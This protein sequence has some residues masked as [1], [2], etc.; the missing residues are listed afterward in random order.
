MP[1]FRSSF[2]YRLFRVFNNKTKV[3]KKKKK[4]SAREL[5]STSLYLFIHPPSLSTP[6]L[7]ILGSEPV[8]KSGSGITV[9][10]PPWILR[11]R[12]RR[13]LRALT[14]LTP[15]TMATVPF[16]RPRSPPQ[17][18]RSLQTPD[19]PRMAITSSKSRRLRPSRVSVSSGIS[20]P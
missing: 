2:C 20:Q 4:V 9:T 12:R 16:A 14:A 13:S 3:K 15:S 11:I 8:D 10:L 7:S 17:T 6:S 5:A 19:P 1:V 18:A